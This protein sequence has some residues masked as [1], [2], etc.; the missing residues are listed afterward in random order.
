[1]VAYAM[2]H[3]VASLAG[4]L[5]AVLVGCVNTWDIGGYPPEFDCTDAGSLSDSDIPD[6]CP[7]DA[8][9]RQ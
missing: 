8:S 9:E 1:M 3:V 7:P 6:T 5:I 2:K 4:L